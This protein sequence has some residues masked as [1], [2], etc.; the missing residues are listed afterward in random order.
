MR[1]CSGVT[2][3]EYGIIAASVAL[4][5]LAIMVLLGGDIASM[6]SNVSEAVNN[7]GSS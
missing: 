1:S 5:F 4:A 2:A 7:A 6:F 3:I